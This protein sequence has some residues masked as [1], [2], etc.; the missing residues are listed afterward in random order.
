MVMPLLSE[1]MQEQIEQMA[2]SVDDLM[3]DSQ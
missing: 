2:Q 3:K 1:E